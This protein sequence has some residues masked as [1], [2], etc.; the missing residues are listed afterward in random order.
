MISVV[1]L[2]VF[3]GIANTL[4]ALFG[5]NKK[6]NVLSIVAAAVSFSVVALWLWS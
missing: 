4:F 3:C 2:L 5:K 1:I 6:L